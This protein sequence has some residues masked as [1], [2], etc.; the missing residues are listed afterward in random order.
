MLMLA[1]SRYAYVN[2]GPRPPYDYVDWA[3]EKDRHN[4]GLNVAF[5]DGHAK[6]F[7][8]AAFQAGSGIRNVNGDSL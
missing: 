7:S 3:A 5:M 2:A 4:D 8:R 6:W 1:E